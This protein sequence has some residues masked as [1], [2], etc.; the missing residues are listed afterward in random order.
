MLNEE[1][2][3]LMTKMASYEG[4]EGKK[5]MAIGKFFRSDYIGI[6]VL[7]SVLSVTICYAVCFALYIFYDFE[8]FM[9]DLYK[10]DLI[11]FAVQV[12]KYYGIA[13]VAYGLLSYVVYSWRYAKAKKSL[14]CYYNNLKKLYSLYQEQ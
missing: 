11:A 2:V 6:Q 4:N 5:N 10:M 9:Q 1:R 14:K 7:K 8:V 12:L 3:I 13:V